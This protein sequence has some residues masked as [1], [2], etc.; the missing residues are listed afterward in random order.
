MAFLLRLHDMC[1]RRNMC[2]S[3]GAGFTAGVLLTVVGSETARKVHKP[4]Q[5][6]LASIPVF[7]F[8]GAFRDSF[9]APRYAPPVTMERRRLRLQRF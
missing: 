9:M 4:S 2:F 8:D 5:I 7:S 6:A 3:A 1:Q